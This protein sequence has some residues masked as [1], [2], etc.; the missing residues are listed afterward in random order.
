M[1][2]MTRVESRLIYLDHNATTP[3][4]PE[5]MEAMT[6]SM[7]VFGNPSSL[8]LPGEEAKALISRARE[9]VAG[10]L[11]VLPEEVIFTGSGSAANNL[12][13][14]GV[15]T[16]YAPADCHIITSQIEHS[17]ILEPC[18]F[19]EKQGY[20]V[21]YLPVDRAGRVDPDDVRRALH[22]TTRLISIMHANNETGVI[23]PIEEIAQIA[24]AAGVLFHTDAVQTVGKLALNLGNHP[25]IHL[26]S[27]TGHKFYGPKGVGALI[28]RQGIDL[29]PLVHGG[30]QENRYRAGTENVLGIAG[31]GAACQ[32]AHLHAATEQARQRSLRDRL[33]EGL[34]ALGDVELNGK[35]TYLVPNTLNASFRFIKGDALAQSLSLLNVAVSTGSACHAQEVEPS[36]VL[37]AMGVP[38]ELR[39]GAIRFSLGKDTTLADIEETLD[40]VGRV[41]RR[42]RAM[43]PLDPARA[44]KAKPLFIGL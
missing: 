44:S 32:R 22:A 33:Y 3:L 17:A 40:A 16:R 35:L 42:L 24:H 9:Q 1:S 12:A 43:S 23:Q 30:G 37:V 39:A 38:E 41:V 4:A 15:A 31:L 36:H 8:N 28:I 6:H 10:L 27:L 25:A 29:C 14:K 5:V 19:L 18:R 2:T 13:I 26:L 21:S 11:N 7:W 34:I 20:R